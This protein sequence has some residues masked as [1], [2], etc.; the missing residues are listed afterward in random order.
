M[1]R[2]PHLVWFGPVALK[3]TCAPDDD[4]AWR[5]IG[6]LVGPAA[7]PRRRSPSPSS[8]AASWRSTRA[9]RALGRCRI[10][11][12]WSSH[13]PPAAQAFA[14]GRREGARTGRAWRLLGLACLSWGCGQ[15]AWTWYEI[16]LG[17]DVPFPSIADI[18]YL[19]FVPLAAAGLLAFPN[20][21]TR[22]SSRVRAV[23]DGLLIASALLFMS[24]M[25]VIGPLFK[26]GGDPFP[27]TIGLAYP[28]GDVVILTLLLFASRHKSQTTSFGRASRCCSSQACSPLRCR[29]A[30]SST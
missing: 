12:S 15:A 30:A 21:P 29:T 2:T 3:R 10:S 25:L 26:A 16:V 6:Q 17:R 23:L 14:R 18:G 8:G 5:S 27:L 9:S 20:V 13:S 11:V 24:W 4:W 1:G 22:L 28:L 19:G 7:W